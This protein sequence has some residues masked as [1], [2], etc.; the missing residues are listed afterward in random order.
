MMP[1]LNAEPP[2]A[3]R[4]SLRVEGVDSIG[5]VVSN[6][7]EAVAFYSRV[8]G[9][10]P[11][12]QTFVEG[13]AHETL[14]AL[15]Q[16][17]A[18][19]ARLRL[20]DET[21]ELT[22]YLSPRGR[23]MPSDSRSQDRWFQHIAIIVSDMDRAYARLRGAGVRHVS[24]GPQ[25]LPDW[26]AQAGGIEAF[27]FED[28][29]GHTLEVLRFPP[30]KGAAKWQRSD[31]RLF[32]GIDHTAIVVDDTE[33]S[34]RFYRDGLGLHVIGESENWG[35]EQERLNHVAGAR[36]R[37]TSLSAGPGPGIELLEYLMPRDGRPYP[38]D[39]R[40]SDLVQ[41]HTRVVVADADLAERRLRERQAAFI[42]P[43]VVTLHGR[44]HGFNRGL[45][46]RD[47]DGH[48]LEIME[49]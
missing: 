44:T 10:E 43:G 48:A 26:N 1:V 11:A 41:W 49:R 42:S 27:Y 21:I 24:P 34:L 23:R 28:A 39:A 22:E 47:P 15:P 8:L 9:F 18:R 4:T 31:D 37:I 13:G 36:L 7:D 20:G 35:P 2:A 12:G 5:I 6:L 46:M 32:L 38:A 14:L 29:D 40:A 16:L 45:L 3:E 17:R 30:G 19:R 25:R 33:R